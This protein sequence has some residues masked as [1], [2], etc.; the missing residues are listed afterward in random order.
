MF[1]VEAEQKFSQYFVQLASTAI[2]VF[3]MRSP[4]R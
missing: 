1:Q 3:W 4:Y 2:L